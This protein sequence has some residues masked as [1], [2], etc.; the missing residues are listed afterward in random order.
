LRAGH[1]VDQVAI[2]VQQDSA[3]WALVDLWCIVS[4]LDSKT[5][6]ILVTE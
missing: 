5:K 3:I 1:L 2:D 4:I 6:P